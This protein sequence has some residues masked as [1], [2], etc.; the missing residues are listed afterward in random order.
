M[1]VPTFEFYRTEFLKYDSIDNKQWGCGVAMIC[2]I[3][4]PFFFYYDSEVNKI[5][6]IEE[7]S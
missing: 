7:I 6:N 1:L 4:I 3:G 5:I 2:L